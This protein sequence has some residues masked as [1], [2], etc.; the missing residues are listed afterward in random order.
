[1]MSI[2]SSTNSSFSFGDKS[3]NEISGKKILHVLDTL[4]AGG[5]ERLVVDIIRGL[6]QFEHH[7]IICNG[8]ETLREEL[9]P[10]CRFTN[11][12]T[13]NRKFY[14]HVWAIKRHVKRY[15]IDL[16]HAYLFF[17]SFI[18]R[19]A[20][21]RKI[22][23]LNSIHSISS[24]DIYTRS[25]LALYL[26]KLTYQK[27]H[28]VIAVSQ[29]ALNDFDKW[30]GLKGP[31]RVLNNFIRDEFFLGTVKQK[32]NLN[33]LRLVAVGNLRYPKN[34][35][36]LLDAFKKMP[37]NVH[38]DIYG[39]GD[40]QQELQAEIDRHRLPVRLMGSCY[41]LHN[42]LPSYDAYVMSSFY[43]GQPLALLEAI[44][45]GL[46]AILSDIPVLREVTKEHALYFDLKNPMDLVQKIERVLQGEID[47]VKNAVPAY[48]NI[49]SFARKEIYFQKLMALYQQ[50]LRT[51]TGQAVG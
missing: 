23:L 51:A 16:V 31:N 1:M 42:V 43:E 20:T 35:H 15:R 38:L 34:Y 37:E 40:M 25:S 5:V 36:Y 44:A 9:P 24:L 12:Q 32:L 45:A 28:W 27:Q 2:D 6:P 4:G 17:P 49:V 39:S 46:P 47:I 48:K 8:P 11:V 26:E 33:C 22:P 10:D 13:R 14:K 29:E 41:N 50:A 21:P 7:L 3:L 30:V 18:T 19:L